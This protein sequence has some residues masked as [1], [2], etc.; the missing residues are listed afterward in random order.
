MSR[1]AATVCIMLLSGCADNK[2]ECGI[3]SGATCKSVTE[4]NKL[5]STGDLERELINK[6]RTVKKQNPY[7]ANLMENEPIALVQKKI[8]RMPEKTARIWVN[9]FSD[10]VGDYVQETYIYT[11]LEGGRWLDVK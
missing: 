7:A 3:G 9:G 8:A 10:E 5:V 11:V 6:P 4:V 2:N 1:I